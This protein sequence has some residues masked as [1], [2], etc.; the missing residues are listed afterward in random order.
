MHSLKV[1]DK[2]PPQLERFSHLWRRIVAAFAPAPKRCRLPGKRCR[3]EESTSL[4]IVETG[5]R[6]V[7]LMLSLVGLCAHH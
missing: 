2:L 5:L 7:T 1:R 6:L 3:F 4:L